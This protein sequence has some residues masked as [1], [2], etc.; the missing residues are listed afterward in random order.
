MDRE[1]PRN[2]SR[3]DPPSWQLLTPRLAVN[4]DYLLSLEEALNHLSPE[5]GDAHITDL[6]DRVRD[7][8]RKAQ[9]EEGADTAHPAS[10]EFRRKGS[11]DEQEET[12]KV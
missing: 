3:D 8:A 9:K 10:H 1:G 6:S 5:S 2:I 11:V 4:R 12:E 7:I